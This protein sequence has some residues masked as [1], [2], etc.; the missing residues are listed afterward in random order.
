MRQKDPEDS[1]VVGYRRFLAGIGQRIVPM[2]FTIEIT[3]KYGSLAGFLTP[4]LDL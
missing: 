2:L 3:G 4:G 1:V